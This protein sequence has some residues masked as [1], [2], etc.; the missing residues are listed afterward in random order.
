MVGAGSHSWQWGCRSSQGEDLTGPELCWH[1]DDEQL[2]T[3]DETW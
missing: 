3:S 2:V 1:S